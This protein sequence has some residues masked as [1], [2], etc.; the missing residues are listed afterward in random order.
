MLATVT[1]KGQVTLPKAI[2]DQLGLREGVR[3]DLQVVDGTLQARPVAGSSL[4]KVIGILQ[5]PGMTAL[6][7]HDMDRAIAH[8]VTAKFGPARQRSSS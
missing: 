7:P 8:A 6:S 1:S 4:D 3:L 2:R 5:R